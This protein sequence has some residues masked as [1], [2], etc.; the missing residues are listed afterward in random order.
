MSWE[1]A[2]TTKDC[3]N[4]ADL[5][6]VVRMAAKDGIGLSVPVRICWEL[7]NEIY[8]VVLTYG[9]EEI[10]LRAGSDPGQS[11]LRVADLAETRSKPRGAK[12]YV[13]LDGEENLY[14]VRG[15]ALGPEQ[16]LVSVYA[17]DEVR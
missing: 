8:P 3:L 11:A 1:I 10:V 13:E 5:D 16:L 15:L 7:R 4:I 6:L 17:G 9:L 2:S 14:G 12:L